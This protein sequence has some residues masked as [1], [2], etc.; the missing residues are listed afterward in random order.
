MD[1]VAFSRTPCDCRGGKL[2]TLDEST[3]D[4]RGTV[5]AGYHV[6]IAWDSCQ[7]PQAGM[8]I[9]VTRVHIADIININD[10]WKK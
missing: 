4:T 3:S 10:E 8:N 6:F 5:A 9:V 2:R 1:Y 7:N